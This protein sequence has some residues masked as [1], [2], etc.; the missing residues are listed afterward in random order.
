MKIRLIE[1]SGLIFRLCS[2]STRR[3]HLTKH[4][5]SCHGSAFCSVSVVGVAC[6]RRNLSER[7]FSEMDTTSDGYVY[8]KSLV[9][10]GTKTPDKPF[11]RRGVISK[12]E[13]MYRVYVESPAR[14]G[15]AICKESEKV[16][17]KWR[18]I[19]AKCKEMRAKCKQIKVKCEE[20][21]GKYCQI[22][23]K[24]E[25]VFGKRNQCSEW[26]SP[27]N[28]KHTE[29]E[30]RFTDWETFLNTPRDNAGGKMKHRIWRSRYVSRCILHSRKKRG[31]EPSRIPY[32]RVI[33]LFGKTR[34]IRDA[35]KL[36]LRKR[37]PS[38]SK[39]KQVLVGYNRYS[40]SDRLARS[41]SVLSKRYIFRQNFYL[42][43]VH[44]RT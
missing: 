38:S 1:C 39:L 6:R 42:S 21:K 17:N 14:L 28:R 41:K 33:K 3:S 36:Y 11:T 15:Y 37:I 35:V 12:G 4:M 26:S 19:K 22:Y 34:K 23:A 10:S 32:K 31:R 2:V 18:Q 43:A 9:Y 20:I 44:V 40:F 27:E 30:S 13:E 8:S 29:S 5:L 7:C 25:R 24:Y 16:R